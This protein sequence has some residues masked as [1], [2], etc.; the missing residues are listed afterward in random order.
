MDTGNI[1]GYYSRFDPDKEYDRHLFRAGKVLQSAEMNEIQEAA[2]HRLKSVADALFKDGDIVRDAA[3]IVNAETGQAICEAGAVYLAG[4][5][6][7]VPEAEFTIPTEGI[8]TIG[9]YLK[10]SVATEQDDPALRD[11][12]QWTR[13]YEM[14]GA[15]R[16]KIAP[17]WGR[18]GDGSEGEFYPV[19][20]V[21]DGVIRAKEPPPQLDAF[22]QAL[23]KYDRDS[24]GG[25][26]V[27]SGMLAAEGEDT[28]E[29]KQVYTITEGRAR[30]NGYGVEFK[31][32][33]RVIYDPQPDLLFIDSEPHMS[34]GTYAQRIETDRHPI[35][36]VTQ[37]RITTERTVDVIHA[38][39]TGGAD[40]LPDN[41]VLAILEVRQGSNVYVYNT[42]YRLTA[43]QVDW[44]PSGSE[45]APGSTYSVTYRY[46]AVVAP[47][48]VDDRGFT[49]TG[50]IEGTLALVS[51]AYLLPRIDRLILNPDG[52]LQWVKG[53]AAQHN[54]I[55]PYVAPGLLPL[56]TIYQTWDASHRLV[57]DSVRTVKMDELW[58]VRARL[59]HI[60]A[61]IAQQRLEASANMI[62]AGIKK[63]L[64]VDPFLD[65]SLRDAGAAQTALILSGELQ[66]SIPADA[67]Q[68]VGDITHP[69]TLAHEATQA[70]A[71]TLKTGDM[72]I[73]PYDAFLPIP[74]QVTLTPAFDNWTTLRTVG[75]SNNDIGRGDSIVSSSSS[76]TLTG[77][78]TAL[79]TLRS[80]NVAFSI[81]GWQA[82]E[83]VLTIRFDGIEIAP[84]ASAG[85]ASGVTTGSFL[86]PEGVTAGRKLVEF[87]G[88]GASYAEAAYEGSQTILDA[89]E[90][91]TRLFRNV[92]PNVNTD[93]L[94]QTFSLPETCQIAAVDLWFAAAG[95][96]QIVIQIRGV[97]NGVPTQE[98][99]AQAYVDP[100]S[101]LANG[102]PTRVNFDAPA[103]LAAGESYAL[104]ALCDDAIARLALAE[105]GKFDVS[106]STFVT[107]Q[108]YQIG[109]MLSSS[110]AATWTAHQ[111]K[112]L[113][114]RLLKAEY[115]ETAREVTLGAAHVEGATDL[116][117]FSPASRPETAAQVAYR[118]TL[119]AEG[120]GAASV[121]MV[122]SG[123]RLQLAA[124]VTGEVQVTALL[125]GTGRVAPIVWPGSQLVFGTL[126]A[127]GD[128]ITRAVP[129]GPD[130]SVKLIFEAVIPAGANVAPAVCGID[131][132]DEWQ[133]LALSK[134]Q[135][136]DEGFVELTYTLAGISEEMIRARLTL[137]G[138]PAARPRV[139]NLRM[140]VT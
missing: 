114:F 90:T 79:D 37:V 1:G 51:Y 112:D 53:V 86:I 29:G 138:T 93:P 104:V 102:N 118:I 40:P 136:M 69:Q 21:E 126:A 60:L 67:L 23:A 24:A 81:Q 110:N 121:F 109:V 127:T 111:D 129:A 137:T 13:N 117:L 82:N 130:S 101:I 63:S 84:A 31:T 132:A 57:N 27:V 39:F 19:Y 5:V 113:T 122:S 49:I 16:L 87:I 47:M 98:I 15:A 35:G 30:V 64:L 3:C 128:Y 108:P 43:G 2:Q 75:S 50:A 6:R 115:T 103:Y 83:A 10:E 88:E 18:S 72:R 120:E 41:S 4:A 116:I 26:Y 74:N 32:S 92:T 52:A 12:A 80:I 105:L 68:L 77:G 135:N 14:P 71:Q 125:S 34:A 56:A 17:R 58:Q 133:A 54:P 123:Q 9:I 78:A 95:D 45:P 106:S 62:E 85:S 140:I 65:D 119:P 89:W 20:T 59:D 22:T 70:L 25:T 7:G 28:P 107:S 94:A 73:N 124:P 99:H 36:S 42:D 139:K 48:N 55:P 131:E 91:V 66:L 8:V 96:G 134:T 33:R 61:L 38:S 46:I 11:P 76:F 44:S 100:D 97:A